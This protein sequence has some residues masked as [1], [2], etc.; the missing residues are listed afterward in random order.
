MYG[1]PFLPANARVG[2][3]IDGYG[4]EPRRARV[5]SLNFDNCPNNFCMKVKTATEDNFN[6][7]VKECQN[8]FLIKMNPFAICSMGI[9][10]LNNQEIAHV[11]QKGLFS[12][13]QIMHSCNYKVYFAQDQVRKNAAH[14][15]YQILLFLKYLH[16]SGFLYLDLKMANIVATHQNGNFISI[17]VIDYESIIPKF[18]QVSDYTTTTVFCSPQYFSHKQPT[19]KDDIWSFG[20][21]LAYFYTGSNPFSANN[22]PNEYYKNVTSA[23]NR[24]KKSMQFRQLPAALQEMIISCLQKDPNM[25]PSVE[26]LLNHKFFSDQNINEF[27]IGTQRSIAAWSQ[28]FATQQSS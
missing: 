13:Q 11:M 17:S 1:L 15:F 18:S 5:Y 26:S 21:I 7:L 12:G 22:D 2:P 10:K 19:E 9:Y 27:Y 6:V 14:I 20:M 8:A 28:M 24:M 25:R 3:A 16:Q 4:N 23:D